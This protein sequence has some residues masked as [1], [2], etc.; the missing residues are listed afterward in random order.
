MRRP[1]HLRPE[2]VPRE[3][4]FMTATWVHPT[5]RE[6]QVSDQGAVVSLV[7]IFNSPAGELTFT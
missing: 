6:L 4:V 1:A 5:D 7:S 2:G 3:A